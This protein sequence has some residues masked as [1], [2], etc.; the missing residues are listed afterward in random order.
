MDVH[1]AEHSSPAVLLPMLLHFVTFLEAELHSST[2]GKKG[3]P[4]VPSST[5]ET[6]FEGAAHT[7]VAK[8]R[9]G[10]KKVRKTAQKIQY[11]LT[12]FTVSQ[13]NFT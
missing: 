3:L 7:L 1:Y 10:I 11:I 6:Q 8:L 2:L 4:K 9:L 5:K 13:V 12:A